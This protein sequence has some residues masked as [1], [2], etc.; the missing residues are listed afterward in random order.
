MTSRFFENLLGKSSPF[1]VA[2]IS[3]NHGGSIAKAKELIQQACECGADAIKLQT[4]TADTMTLNCNREDFVVK[5]GLW[6]G[7]TLYP[8]T[9]F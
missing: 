4:Y 9:L 3:A 6:A 1:I 2:E 8:S 7:R 5:E